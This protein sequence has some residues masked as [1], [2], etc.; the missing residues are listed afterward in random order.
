MQT[1]YSKKELGRYEEL[2]EGIAGA[3]GVSSRMGQD[4]VE[5]IKYSSS[6]SIKGACITFPGI[7]Q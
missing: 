5:E 7:S 6:L 1:P 4:E 2:S 3:E